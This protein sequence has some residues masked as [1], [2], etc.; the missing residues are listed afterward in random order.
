LLKLP[1]ERRLPRLGTVATAA[2]SL[3]LG[4]G[5]HV[6]VGCLA[7]LLRDLKASSLVLLPALLE[8][9]DLLLEVGDVAPREPLRDESAPDRLFCVRL[10]GKPKP[11]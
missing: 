10:G 1:L 6:E 11:S 4:L 5:I 2:I 9:G 3:P 8:L 7:K